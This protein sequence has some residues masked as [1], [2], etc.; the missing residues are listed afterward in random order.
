MMNKL[1]ADNCTAVTA[2]LDPPGPPLSGLLMPPVRKPEDVVADPDPALSD[3]DGTETF[4]ERV[5]TPVNNPSELAALLSAPAVSD[6]T[7]VPPACLETSLPFDTTPEAVA[8]PLRVLRNRMPTSD[9]LENNKFSSRKL[10]AAP[11]SATPPLGSQLITIRK[12]VVTMDPA[13][14]SRKRPMTRSRLDVASEERNASDTENHVNNS[15]NNSTG[16]AS[17]SKRSRKSLPVATSSSGSNRILRSGASPHVVVRSLR[18]QDSF[19]L[20]L[21]QSGTPIHLRKKRS[22]S[23][24]PMKRRK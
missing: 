19:N 15:S 22:R 20:R 10:T 3:N 8:T 17:S 13:C 1:R 18:S 24:T 6:V 16:S 11:S 12:K 4:E 7:P 9:S 5:Q 14:L 23:F 2:L 21:G